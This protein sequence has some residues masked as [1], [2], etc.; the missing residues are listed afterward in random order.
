VRGKSS[1]KPS[2]I[3]CRPLARAAR[4]ALQISIPKNWRICPCGACEWPT[5]AKSAPNAESR[6]RPEFISEFDLGA[7]S[8]LINSTHCPVGICHDIF[9][10]E[11]HCRRG[12]SPIQ[13][14]LPLGLLGVLGAQKRDVME[15]IGDI[16]EIQGA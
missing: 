8:A 2:P 12:S 11:E 14:P 1:A 9:R 16:P 7:K 5:C 4:A 10:G 6:R 3:A 15:S 13:V